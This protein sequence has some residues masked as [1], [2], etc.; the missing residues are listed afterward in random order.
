MRAGVAISGEGQTSRSNEGA[1]TGGQQPS[2]ISESYLKT[3]ESTSHNN[4]KGEKLT[5]VEEQQVGEILPNV[6]WVVV[7]GEADLFAFPL[8]CYTSLLSHEGSRPC[9]AKRK[10]MRSSGHA[11]HYNGLTELT[12][13]TR[14]PMANSSKHTASLLHKSIHSQPQQLVWLHTSYHLIHE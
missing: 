2:V 3:R 9:D 6:I 13:I 10:K 7:L 12:S 14:P 4:F 8:P 1:Y 11:H 5:C